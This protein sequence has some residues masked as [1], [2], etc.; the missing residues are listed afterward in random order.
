MAICHPLLLSRLNIRNPQVIVI[1]EW[2]EGR[3]SRADLGIHS[4]PCALSLD[5][6]RLHWRHLQ[7]QTHK[8]FGPKSA[9]SFRFEGLNHRY[10]TAHEMR[11]NIALQDTREM[12]ITKQMQM[13]SHL[14]PKQVSVSGDIHKIPSRLTMKPFLP[15]SR[16]WKRLLLAWKR[17]RP[18]SLWKSYDVIPKTPSRLRSLKSSSSLEYIPWWGVA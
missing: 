8:K 12:I 10:S 16:Q 3:I 7:Q 13:C 6:Q 17:N 5:L 14:P 15:P 2:K 18:L 9:S 4:R 1:N 11:A